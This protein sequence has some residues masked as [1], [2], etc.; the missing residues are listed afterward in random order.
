[1]F[2]QTNNLPDFKEIADSKKGFIG[3]VNDFISI[4]DSDS[5]KNYVER[6]IT[7]LLYVLSDITNLLKGTE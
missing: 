6:P 2:E 3:I 5:F 1:M 7:M 4:G